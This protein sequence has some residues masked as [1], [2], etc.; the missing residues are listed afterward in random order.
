LW[1]NDVPVPTAFFAS[2]QC[3]GLEVPPH[4]AIIHAR[5]DYG[6]G[7]RRFLANRAA[8]SFAMPAHKKQHFVPRCAL[9]PFTLDSAGAAINLVNIEHDKIVRNAPVKGQCAR[10]Y[11]YGKH[12][13]ATEKLLA[14]LEGHYARIVGQLAEGNAPSEA[15]DGWLRLFINIQ[16]RR[17]E[18]AI[19]TYRAVTDQLVD[20]IF[21]RSPQ[22]RPQVQTDTELI[23]AS[24]AVAISTMDYV[25]DLKL[26]IL[27]NGTNVD[28]VTSDH[29]AA[30][31]NRFHFQKLDTANFGMSNS[32]LTLSMPL[33]PKL[34]VLLYDRGVYTL[35]NVS[36]TPFIELT[37][38]ENVNAINQLQYVSASMNL[39]FKEWT[40]VERIQSEIK[41]LPRTGPSFV[42]TVLIPI[43]EMEGASDLVHIDSK[44]GKT[45]KYRKATP[46][47]ETAAKE[48]L[49]MT[50]FHY[51]KPSLWFSPLKFRD[52]PTTFDNGSAIGRVRKAEWLSTQ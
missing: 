24:L 23:H 10:D 37:D 39:Y 42:T 46:D 31:T 32:G 45:R 3:G 16:Q 9:K 48:A 6:L 35:P 5:A 11:L 22:Q 25:N 44:T 43:E 27:R 40:D 17:T 8:S 38:V 1:N 28:F 34:S 33:S 26:L 7:A 36:G 29:P 50:S 21:A 15:D 12:S 52:K 19:K 4:A 18:L 51:Q 49:I 41:T 2:P 13:L 30:I 47:E 14:E 20:K